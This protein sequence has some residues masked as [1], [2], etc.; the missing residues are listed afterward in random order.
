MTKSACTVEQRIEDR[1]PADGEIWIVPDGP[2]SLEIRGRLIDS[3]MSGFRVSHSQM[4]L[5]AGQRVYFCHSLSQGRAVVIWNRILSQ[6]V[7]T[8]FFITDK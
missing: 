1:K 2:C 7:E 8:G 5:S 3:S 4:T 6:H